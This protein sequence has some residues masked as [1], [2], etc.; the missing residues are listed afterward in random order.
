MD[1]S[2]PAAYFSCRLT[3]SLEESQRQVQELLEAGNGKEVSRLKIELQENIAGKSI[4]QTLNKD[5][6]EEIRELKEQVRKRQSTH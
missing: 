3:K 2:N 4:A 1:G 6:Q 5:L